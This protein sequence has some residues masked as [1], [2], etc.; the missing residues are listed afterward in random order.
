MIIRLRHYQFGVAFS[1]IFFY[2][3]HLISPKK[4][5]MTAAN[6][7]YYLTSFGLD[8]RL[9]TTFVHLF[10]LWQRLVHEEEEETEEKSGEEKRKKKKRIKSSRKQSEN[11]NK[12]SAK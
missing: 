6:R 10:V 9:M 11:T 12:S 5:T 3:L 4:L 7:E 1:S 8:S 2:L